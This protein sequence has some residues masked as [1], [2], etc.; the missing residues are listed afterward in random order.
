M[1]AC[2]TA[3]SIIL[4]DAGQ[5]YTR[6]NANYTIQQLRTNSPLALDYYPEHILERLGIS[7]LLIYRDMLVE[8]SWRKKLKVLKIINPIRGQPKISVMF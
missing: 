2:I 1:H 8:L 6:A 4:S 3:N 7:C 5:R